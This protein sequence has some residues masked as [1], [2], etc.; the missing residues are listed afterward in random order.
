MPENALAESDLLPSSLVDANGKPL[1]DQPTI[2][3]DGKVVLPAESF[4]VLDTSNLRGTALLTVK[5]PALIVTSIFEATEDNPT[6]TDKVMMSYS[7]RK[8]CLQLA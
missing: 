6:F 5:S 2:K 4:L 7:S 8:Y 3:E 1:E